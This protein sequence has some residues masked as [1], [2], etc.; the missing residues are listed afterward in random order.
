MLGSKMKT[1]VAAVFLLASCCV[2]ACQ[3]GF[4]LLGNDEAKSATEIFVFR[5]VSAT[6]DAN[7]SDPIS[8]GK[9]SATI[10]I[11]DVLRGNPH[12]NR[13]RY[14]TSLC[15]GS[16]IDVGQYFVAFTSDSGME[17]SANTGNL[18]NFGE[19]YASSAP[20]AQRLR[21]VESGRQTLEEAFGKFP[22]ER[23][24]TVPRPPDPCPHES[25][26]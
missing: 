21:A 26:Q 15:C 1:L 23:M 12:F 10:Q 17:F 5:L 6:A 16:R 2:S 20:N 25:I 13:M 19:Q 7:D 8:G 14:S 3:C 4:S 18:M 11:V 9:V 24:F 22:N